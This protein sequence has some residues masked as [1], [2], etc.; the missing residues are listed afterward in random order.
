LRKGCGRHRVLTR[1]FSLWSRTSHAHLQPQEE[2]RDHLVLSRRSVDITS[3]L[4]SPHDACSLARHAAACRGFV[5]SVAEIRA[6]RR[7]RYVH[8]F[9][10]TP[11]DGG[12]YA[13]SAHSVG[14]RGQ[15]GSPSSVPTPQRSNGGRQERAERDAHQLLRND[16][17]CWS[18]DVLAVRREGRLGHVGVEGKDVRVPVLATSC[19]V[20]G[21]SHVPECSD[22]RHVVPGFA[23]TKAA[24]R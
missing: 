1:L 7:A 6:Q 23:N 4:N 11:K 8:M 14:G 15:V 22:G 10:N 18:H 16:L 13:H 21:N 3:R 5:L 19:A 12:S 17:N 24:F 9:T 2:R 20:V